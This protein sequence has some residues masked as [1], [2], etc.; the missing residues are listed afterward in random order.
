MGV[1]PP[2]GP[3]IVEVIY[4]PDNINANL[5]MFLWVNFSIQ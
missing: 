3:I 5:F 2:P 4:D 1:V